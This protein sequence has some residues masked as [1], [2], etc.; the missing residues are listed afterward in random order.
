MRG[1]W[2]GLFTLVLACEDGRT[3]PVP[4]TPRPV[5]ASIPLPDAGTPRDAGPR[6]DG[7]ERGD[8]AA[9]AGDAGPCSVAPVQPRDQACCL[10]HG[11]DACAVGA[12]C[13]AL[14]GRTVPVCYAD[15][16]RR[17]GESCSQASQC[18]SGTCTGGV[19]DEARN[20]TTAAG[21]LRFFEGGALLAD[22][23]GVPSFP[24]GLPD[25]VNFGESTQCISSV[26]WTTRAGQVTI[27]RTE[28]TLEGA[29]NL[30]D[31][32]R[33]LRM[34]P[35]VEQT[36]TSRRLTLGNIRG[37]AECFDVDL[38]L[39]ERT[40]QGRGRIAADGSRVELELFFESLAQ[41]IRCA[42]GDVCAPTVVFGG[43]QFSGDATFVFRR[44]A[45]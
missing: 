27:V 43:A 12:S 7:G 39:P 34:A 40:W 26:R 37:N 21:I 41:G 22:P 14:D 32:G 42:D 13:A 11:P 45:R 25:N 9:G 6:T 2:L 5:D 31:V 1:L 29:P 35:S 38:V 28:G 30:S 16:S 4:N 44:V 17:A 24:F 33:C 8:G 10:A 3:V 19:C 36:F 15:G 18:S 23:S 20:L